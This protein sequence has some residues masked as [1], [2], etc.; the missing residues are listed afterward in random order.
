[1]VD[2]PRRSVGLLFASNTGLS[3]IVVGGGGNALGFN[4]F[5]WSAVPQVLWASSLLALVVVEASTSC[6]SSV[7]GIITMGAAPPACWLY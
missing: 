4:S 5:L 1:V 3:S 2:A 7:V 6:R